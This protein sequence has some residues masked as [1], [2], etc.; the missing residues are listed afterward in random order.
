MTS[1]L[2]GK[3]LAS[4][5]SQMQAI[6]EL[7]ARVRHLQ[8]QGYELLQSDECL[9]SVDAYVQKHWAPSGQPI[10]KDTRWSSAKPIVVFGCIS[11]TRGVVHWHFGEG[12]F[13]AQQIADAL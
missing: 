3:R 9:F 12:S 8:S 4:Q 13:N 7:Q 2:G 5:Q 6:A 11:P 10:R 1:R